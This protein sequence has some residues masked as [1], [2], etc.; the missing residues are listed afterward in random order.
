LLDKNALAWNC[1]KQVLLYILPNY[2]MEEAT[3]QVEM[4]AQNDWNRLE[5]LHSRL[6]YTDRETAL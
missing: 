6:P 4:E 5:N 3:M 1:V 2:D